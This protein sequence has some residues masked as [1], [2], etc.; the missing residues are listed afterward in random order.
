MTEEVEN[1]LNKTTGSND[2]AVRCFKNKTT[3]LKFADDAEV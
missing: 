2:I 1:L 3:K